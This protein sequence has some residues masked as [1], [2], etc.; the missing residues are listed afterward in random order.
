MVCSL[1]D[2]TLFF[3]APFVEI[4]LNS[5]RPVSVRKKKRKHRY[6]TPRDAFEVGCFNT[7]SCCSHVVG[8]QVLFLRLV[9][10]A[11]LWGGF[12]ALDV[13]VFQ[14]YAG[15]AGELGAAVR[16]GSGLVGLVR[17]QLALVVGQRQGST[18]L[19]QFQQLSWVVFRNYAG[20]ASAE[21]SQVPGLAGFDS[22]APS[23]SEAHSGEISEHIGRD[24]PL[25]DLD[26]VLFG[27]IL[28]RFVGTEHVGHAKGGSDEHSECERLHDC[29]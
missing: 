23:R 26:R 16:E 14:L 15:L 1:F 5:L 4:S 18:V 2:N 27:G 8:C 3:F 7:L 24:E 12:W 11:V 10:L 25:V 22:G 28:W 20:G 6:R 17:V 21:W 13:R 29:E 9:L 19:N